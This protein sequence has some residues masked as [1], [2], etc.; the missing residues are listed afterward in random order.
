M[1]KEILYSKTVE[2]NFAE[3]K[4]SKAKRF[5]FYLCALKIL[6]FRLFSY[7]DYFFFSLVE[8]AG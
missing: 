7:L 6:L 8:F 3:N 1:L 5:F 2:I 4:L